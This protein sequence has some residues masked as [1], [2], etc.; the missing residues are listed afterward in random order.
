M[1]EPLAEALMVNMLKRQAPEGTV[2]NAL[3][4]RFCAAIHFA[5]A[6]QVRV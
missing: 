1:F 3:A 6:L 4:K 2:L 5:F